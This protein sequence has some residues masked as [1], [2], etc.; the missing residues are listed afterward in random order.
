MARKA[1]LSRRQLKRIC[2]QLPR[3]VHTVFEPLA[4]ALTR[5]THRRLVLLALAAILTV[6]GRTIANLLRTLGALAPGHSSS[7]HRAL[8]HRRWSTRRLARRYIAA[9]LAR[10]VPRGPVELAGDD[11]VTEHPGAKGYGKGS[12]YPEAN[13]FAPPPPVV[14]RR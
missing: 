3:P 13:L 9:V 4:P 10:F 1:G 5:P 6:G 14:G 12:F 7:Y 2:G 8:S 11:T